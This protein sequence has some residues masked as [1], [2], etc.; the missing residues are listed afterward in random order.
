MSWPLTAI[1]CPL[2]GEPRVFTAR[3]QSADPLG[4]FDHEAYTWI[5]LPKKNVLYH[6]QLTDFDLTPGE[7]DAALRER[8]LN[9]LQ[10]Q[11]GKQLPASWSLDKIWPNGLAR[12]RVH[13]ALVESDVFKRISSIGALS[14]EL[15]PRIPAMHERNR[16][17]MNIH[18]LSAPSECGNNPIAL[19]THSGTLGGRPQGRFG[20][21]TS[22]Y[23]PQ[24]A[25][26]SDILS[27]R[28]TGTTP[29]AWILRQAQELITLSLAFYNSEEERENAIRPVI[30]RV[31]PGAKWHHKLPNGTAT[32]AAVWEGQIFELKNE[33]GSS[34]DPTAQTIADY[35][36][37]VDDVEGVESLGR[38]RSHSIMPMILLSLASTQFEI[39]GAIYTDMAQVDHLFSMNFYDSI[40]LEDQVLALGGALMALQATLS[41]LK[42]YYAALQT[43][44][45]S[46]PKDSSAIHLPFPV[47]AEQP[48]TPVTALLDLQ[49]LYKLSRLTGLAIDPLLN[50]DWE[51]NTRHA[52]FVALGSD[53][54]Q[55]V[56]KFARRYN[57]EAHQL[58]ANLSLAPKLH[59]HCLVRGGLTMVVMEKITGQMASHLTM[60]LAS[61]VLRDIRQAVEVLHGRGIVFGDLRLPNIMVYHRHG[62]ERAVLIDFDW[63]ANAGEGR[64]P[65]TIS[66]LSIWAP[67]V[68]P[69]AIMQKAHDLHLLDAIEREGRKGTSDG[70]DGYPDNSSAGTSLNQGK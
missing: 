2:V 10:N 70:G 47:S 44:E 60:P 12:D 46:R 63:A 51:A 13:L 8:L 54:V 24:L 61:S 58:L 11:V 62:E 55:V 64:Y 68:A 28:S 39:C 26:L 69:Y 27:K 25:A 9:A 43:D 56:V 7:S 32:P 30:D 23:S 42:L 40:Y 66:D 57:V 17:L 4:V 67:T 5:D 21:P 29:T 1:Y 38:L 33:R 3:A 41:E 18:Q 16:N 53:G 48:Y 22:L 45:G 19:Y 52:V 15:Q 59:H 49:F 6:F 37:I 65:A 50:G 36:K 14:V 35:E 31:F 34:G 20:L